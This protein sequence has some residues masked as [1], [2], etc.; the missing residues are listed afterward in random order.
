M[1]PP[2]PLCP[3]FVRIAARRGDGTGNPA[4]FLD[5][6]PHPQ[7]QQSHLSS[8]RNRINSIP[9]PQLAL[10]VLVIESQGLSGYLPVWSSTVEYTSHELRHAV[11]FSLGSQPVDRAFCPA[12]PSG[13]RTTVP[14]SKTPPRGG[15]RAT[16]PM[17]QLSR[18]AVESGAGAPTVGSGGIPVAFAPV[19]SPAPLVAFPAPAPRTRRAD[20]R[21]RAL[22]RDHAPRTQ[23]TKAATARMGWP[24]RCRPQKLHGFRPSCR[25]ALVG[26]QACQRLDEPDPGTGKMR[27]RP[28]A[29][30]HF[31][32]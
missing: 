4:E 31:S 1:S 7:G 2:P 24:H 28:G 11:R 12:Q 20:F 21:H 23:A 19:L 17:H 15:T 3:Y 10:H 26:H 29:A 25:D 5:S 22:Q 13:G 27:R 32:M 8:C 30:L 14:D 9:R 18:P 6:S 16:M